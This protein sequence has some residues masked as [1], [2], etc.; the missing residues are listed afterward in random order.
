MTQ[1]VLFADPIP[2][3]PGK[4]MVTNSAAFEKMMQF[5]AARPA[6]AFDFE[7]TGLD[8]F[9]NAQACGL[10]LGALDEAGRVRAYY[11]PFRHT[12]GKVAQ[13]ALD[14]IAPAIKALLGDRNTLKIAHNIKFDEHVAR[15]EGWPV[16]GPRYDTMIAAHFFDENRSA[17]LKNRAMED[18]GIQAAGEYEGLVNGRIYQLAKSKK[19]SPTNYKA[20]V[21]YSEVP[22]DVLGIYACFDIDFTLQLHQKY[23]AAGV[24]ARCGQV[25]QTEM[26]LTRVIGDMEAWGLLVDR[27][28]L[29]GLR[30]TLLAERERLEKA[31]EHALGGRGFNYAS[32]DETRDFLVSRL[33][34]QLTKKTERGQFSVDASVIRECAEAHPVLV[35]LAAW[36]EVDK[37]ANTYTTSILSRADAGDIVHPDFRQVGTK[38]GRLSCSKPNF[39]NFPTDDNDR[40]KACGGADLEHGG[41]DPWSIR[42]AFTNRGPGWVRLFWDYSQIELRVLAYYSRDPI[43]VQAYLS[44]AD[45]HARTSQE[46]FGNTEKSN[47]RLAKVINFGTCIAGGQ[48]VLTKQ[49]GLVPIENVKDWHLVWDGIE[50]VSHDGLVCNGEKNVVTYDGVTATPDHLVFLKEGFDAIPIGRL[51]SSLCS[52]SLAVGAVGEIPH[53]YSGFDGDFRQAGEAPFGRSNLSC[54]SCPKMDLCGQ[55]KN[56]IIPELQMPK[57]EVSRSSGGVIGGA[58]RLHGAAVQSGYSSGFSVLQGERDQGFICFSGAFYPLGAGAISPSDFQRFGFRS[59]RQR[60]PL[61]PRQF[62]IDDPGNKFAK[63]TKKVYDL[64]NAGPRHRFTVE[65]KIVS[66]SYGMAAKGF[67]EQ[68]GVPVD[69]AQQFLNLFFERYKGV[70]QF[71]NTFWGH[72]RNS[73]G[74]FSNLFGRPRRV[75][76]F[77]SENIWEVRSAER[78]SIAALIQG[79]AAELTKAGLVRLDRVFTARGLEAHICNTVHDEIQIDCR[80]DA[81]AEVCRSTR[82]E[83]ER[84]PEFSPIPIL[85]DGSYTV[86]SWAEKTAL[87]KN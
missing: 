24:A 51:A 50:W 85:V 62:K 20:A 68:T 28:Y 34:L 43:M 87:P 8:H 14:Q 79:S 26:D 84:F 71:R 37:L 46:V 6:I 58:L 41:I 7:T 22:L 53:G 64:I 29:E 56:G 23:E 49:N 25:W 48:R 31:M 13:L 9:Q 86:T 39:Q 61:Q 27:P 40:A 21:G 63:Q 69:Q 11:V 81:L 72:L 1:E 74:A 35:T 38:T 67:S 83:L 18:L 57:G 3:V 44:G 78:R 54:L 55:Y 30:E 2:S 15:R 52:R 10:G 65:G 12:G 36:R 42:R 47:R 82:V 66:N 17:A 73:G 45:I 75:L 32:D 4:T 5:L 16:L 19:L 77:D 33:K 60:W 59:D 76:G 80:V 70:D